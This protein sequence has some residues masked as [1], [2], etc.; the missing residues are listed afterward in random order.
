V[1][2]L[3]ALRK[4]A[5]WSVAA[6]WS[7]EDVAEHI[8]EMQRIDDEYGEIFDELTRSRR[9]ADSAVSSPPSTR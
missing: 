7:M 2:L 6:L 9:T 4:S 8:N 5:V 3:L 1:R